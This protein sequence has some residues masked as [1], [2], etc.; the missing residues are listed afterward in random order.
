MSFFSFYPLTMFLLQ[1]MLNEELQKFVLLLMGIIKRT[2]RHLD[3]QPNVVR[4]LRKVGRKHFRKLNFDLTRLDP[5]PI[6]LHFVNSVREI[7]VS[8]RL[9]T[10]EVE[11]SYVLLVRLILFTVQKL[12]AA[13]AFITAGSPGG[14]SSNTETETED[15]DDD[16]FDDDDFDDEDD[17]EEEDPHGGILGLKRRMEGDADNCGMQNVFPAFDRQLVLFGCQTFQDFFD[18]NPHILGSFDQFSEI[19]LNDAVTAADAL[20]MHATRVLSLA[21]D[22]IGSAGNP[23]KIRT[24]L[25]DLGRQHRRQGITEEQLDMLGPV[26][27]HTV[28]PVVFRSG[29]WSVEVEKSWA[30]LFDLVAALM[31]EGHQSQRDED[32]KVLGPISAVIVICI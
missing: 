27:C 25:R 2:V 8:S 15:D 12:S 23:D 6:S 4:M 24:M 20:K 26:V 22:I 10:E 16:D 3:H 31:K 21:E 32:E 1:V 18:A 17:E 11:A 29:L 28:R 19:Q 9:W 14:T 13:G 7:I 30:H 5:D